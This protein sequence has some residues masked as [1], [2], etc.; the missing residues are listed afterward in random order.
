LLEIW[1][2]LEIKP[3]QRWDDEIKRKLEEAELYIFFMSAALLD[4]EYVLTVELPIARRRDKEGKARLVPVIIRDCCWKRYVG[5]IQ[6]LPTRGHAVKTWRDRDE[7]CYNVEEGLRRAI[8]E[9]HK[10]L[11]VS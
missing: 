6:A 4:S 8:D 5:D 9:M 1:C 7:A 3:G 11:N 10:L 2:D